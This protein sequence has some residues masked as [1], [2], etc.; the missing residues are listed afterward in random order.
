MR[1]TT[2][3]RIYVFSILLL[4]SGCQAAIKDP[5]LREQA[6]L[7]FEEPEP[8]PT[9]TSLSGTEQTFLQVEPEPGGMLSLSSQ[10]ETFLSRHFKEPGNSQICVDVYIIPLLREG[11]YIDDVFKNYELTLDGEALPAGGTIHGVVDD[12][13]TIEDQGEPIAT[14]FSS[15]YICWSP[16]LTTGIHLAEIKIWTSADE[17]YRYSWAFKVVK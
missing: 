5:A 12:I 15:D 11:D 9:T 3:S 14:S 7:L 10:D 1:I 2:L 8:L 6:A 4:L 17:E 16:S 13:V